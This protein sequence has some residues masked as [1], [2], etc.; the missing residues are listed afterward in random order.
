MEALRRAARLTAREARTMGV[1]WNL[2]PVCDLD[3]GGP[4]PVLG[5]RALGSDGA[6]VARLATAWIEAC[7]AEGV[8]ACAKH[9]PGLG[10]V[11]DDPH[12]GRAE[13]RATRDVLHAE[14]LAPFRAAFAAN[15]ASVMTAHVA[16]PALDPSGTPAT[17][18]REVITW[19]LRQQLR[20]E[21][22]VVTDALDMRG[23]LGAAA[24]EAD[25]A[26]RAIAAGCDVVLAPG[27]V[28]GTVAALDRALASHA[29]DPARVQQSARRRLKWAQWASP[30]NDWRRPAATDLMWGAQLADRVVHVLRGEPAP[31]GDALDV[32]VVDDAAHGARDDALGRTAARADDR[33]ALFEALHGAGVT[34]RAVDAVAGDGAGPVAVALFGGEGWPSPYSDAALGRVRDALAAA[35]A[36]GR[37]ATLLHFAHPRTAPDADGAA[38]VCAWSGDRAMQQAVARWLA[39][40]HGAAR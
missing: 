12:L 29:L 27:D 32:V 31:L 1:N 15:V 39:A 26:V 19:L 6:T 13:V 38:V 25:A 11:T 14:D 4:S 33:M 28:A 35:A 2:S 22:L 7:Q 8:L 5:A 37:P 17:L 18:S 34:A 40:R 3:L 24:D 20:Y 30:P 36:A 16:Y 23:V 21:G 9:F 10:R